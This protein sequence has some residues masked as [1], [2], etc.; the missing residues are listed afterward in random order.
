MNIENLKVTISINRF[1]RA[2]L[3]VVN[4]PLALLGRDLVVPSWC[5]TI[6]GPK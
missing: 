3:M 1:Q 6:K 2:A 4:F 5:I